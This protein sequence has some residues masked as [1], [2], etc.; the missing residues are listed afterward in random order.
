MELEFIKSFLRIDSEDDDEILKLILEAAKEYVISAVGE[1]DDTKPKVKLLLLN[2]ISSM[3]DNRSYTVVSTDKQSEKVRYTIDSIIK[4]L[5]IEKY[6]KDN[7][8]AEGGSS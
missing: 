6:I 1:C 5:K 7:E 2:L 8:V 4:Q 3:Y